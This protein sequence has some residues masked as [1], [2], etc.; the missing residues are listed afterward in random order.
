MAWW[1]INYHGA[2]DF[3]HVSYVDSVNSDGSID[4]EDYNSA[5]TGMYAT[6]HYPAGSPSWPSGFIH[7]QDLSSSGSGGGVQGMT[8]LGTDR[9]SSYSSGSIRTS[10]YCPSTPGMY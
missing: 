1:D 9:L 4:T 10:T 3:G 7:V 5:G 8:F 2:S 6:H